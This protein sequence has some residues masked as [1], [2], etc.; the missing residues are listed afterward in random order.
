VDDFQQQQLQQSVRYIMRRCRPQRPA[1]QSALMKFACSV[2][3][4][5]AYVTR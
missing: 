5:D 4:W 1:S 3:V 2:V